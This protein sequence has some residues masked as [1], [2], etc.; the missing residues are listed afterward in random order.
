[1]T[2]RV[3]MRRSKRKRRSTRDITLRRESIRSTTRNQLLQSKRKKKRKNTTR[4]TRKRRQN[5]RRSSE[6]EKLRSTARVNMHLPQRAHQEDQKEP[7]NPKKHQLDQLMITTLTTIQISNLERE[8]P[9]PFLMDSQG[10]KLHNLK[11]VPEDQTI[12]LKN[13]LP[14]D[15]PTL[16]ERKEKPALW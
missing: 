8:M 4:D 7:Q 9:Q 16:M 6:S 14:L 10:K 15:T 1:M 2:K 3:M 11:L 12:H 13:N 5:K